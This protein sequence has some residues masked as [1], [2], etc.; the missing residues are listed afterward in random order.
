[1]EVISIVEA[2]TVEDGTSVGGSKA[3]DVAPQLVVTIGM[4]PQLKQI[5]SMQPVG[6]VTSSLVAEAEVVVKT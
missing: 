5:S 1:L 4:R 6:I 2:A 3:V